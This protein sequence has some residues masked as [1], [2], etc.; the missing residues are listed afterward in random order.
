MSNLRATRGQA[1]GINL[2]AVAKRAK[3]AENAAQ[4]VRTYVSNLKRA[5]RDGVASFTKQEIEDHE[6]LRASLEQLPQTRAYTRLMAWVYPSLGFASRQPY[7]WAVVLNDLDD[8]HTISRLKSLL[9][10]MLQMQS[11]SQRPKAGDGDAKP[12]EA[13]A[14]EILKRMR[15]VG[16]DASLHRAPLGAE[17]DGYAYVI[18]IAHSQAVHDE[19]VRHYTVRLNM[20][21][22]LD[23][24]L[25]RITTADKLTAIS[26]LLTERANLGH[27]YM[28]P[29]EI[30][31][32]HDDLEVVFASFPLH[33]RGFN[34]KLATEWGLMAELS[35]AHLRLVRDHYGEELAWYFALLDFTVENL[36]PVAAIGFIVELIKLGGDLVIY[37]IVWVV[38]ASLLVFWGA[39]FVA[40]WRRRSA[41]LRWD[42][43]VE[44][45][46]KDERRNPQYKGEWRTDS[47]SGLLKPR[48]SNWDR[49]PAFANTAFQ[50]LIQVCLLTFIEY[51][52]YAQF[53]WAIETY[54]GREGVYYE[55]MLL[56]QTMI[57]NTVI[58][59]GLIMFGQYVLWS[60][61]ANWTTH[62]EQWGYQTQ[63]DNQYIYYVFIFIWLDG[64]FWS[65]F[66]G[67]I[68]IPLVDLNVDL[69]SWNFPIFGQLIHKNRSADYW[70]E[71]HD[72][73]VGS[74]LGMNQAAAFCFENVLPLILVTMFRRRIHSRR[75]AT[76]G[77]SSADLSKEE[78]ATS[79]NE[80][81]SGAQLKTVKTLVP[82]IGRTVDPNEEPAT[83]KET[84]QAVIQSLDERTL[85]PFTTQDDYYDVIL[86]IGY[87]VTYT[88]IW[89]LTPVACY[90]NNQIELRTDL[91][92][93]NEA[94]RRIIPKKTR[95]IGAWEPCMV[96]SIWA[97]IPMVVTFA[98]ISTRTAEVLFHWTKD[99]EHPSHSYYWND[100]G[101]EPHL[102]WWWRIFVAFVWEHILA[103]GCLIIFKVI[104]RVPKWVNEQQ[105]AARIALAKEAHA[106]HVERMTKTETKVEYTKPYPTDSPRTAAPARRVTRQVPAQQY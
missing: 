58:Y 4:A 35:E 55:Y 6:K 30:T 100:D 69:A 3:G 62:K 53:V 32:M 81:V 98:T 49:I 37:K 65:W 48:M 59:V 63:F 46:Q 66:F 41:E 104:P 75:A 28:S 16:L 9:P 45:L 57:V 102:R 40:H 33:D 83:E 64:Y 44:S 42:W 10:E 67:Y 34:L 47:E 88:V 70:M 51:F 18:L 15:D 1:G 93:I 25:P 87:I 78:L 74:M 29:G 12:G 91:L 99:V 38:F 92:K 97:A 76:V 52:S 31:Y 54:D 50:M 14:R 11:L 73:M 36:F 17:E 26:R 19:Y 90:I 72:L 68:H 7:L 5:E 80:G 22:A 27:Q 96:F 105:K 39:Y 56:F 77:K 82:A 13:S 8:P 21:E 94:F 84:A 103:L 95:G 20:E 71:K 106:D 86:F 23:T 79:I 101:D 85:A 43:K 89:P 61:V 60:K 2:R 24:E